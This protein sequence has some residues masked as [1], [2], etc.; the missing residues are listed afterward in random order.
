MNQRT[1]NQHQKTPFGF[2]IPDFHNAK[3]KIYFPEGEEVTLYVDFDKHEKISSLGFVLEGADQWMAA[4]SFFC[5]WSIGK[6]ANEV[7]THDW[8]EEA[9]IKETGSPVL[10]LPLLLLNQ[11][12]REYKGTTYSDKIQSMNASDLL[13]R[14]FSV[15]RPQLLALAQKEGVKQ[16]DVFLRETLAG[17]GCGTCRADIESLFY[18]NQ[19]AMEEQALKHRPMGLLPAEF[20]IQIDNWIN[21]WL[22]R[23]KVQDQIQ[24]A[25]I[26]L[27]GDT[28]ILRLNP[29]QN[30]VKLLPSFRD[31]LNSK[32]VPPYIK[33]S[34]G[35]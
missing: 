15:Y 10:F 28:L 12:W 23:E 4:F 7:M 35:D 31:Y 16:L 3:A 8:N 18:Q 24:M 27:A 29:K 2:G 6:K 32:G 5:E 13:C 22:E 33:L 34:T 21:E 19:I 26:L 20:L 1:F 25:P 30:A 11:C 17:Q 9:I 14:C